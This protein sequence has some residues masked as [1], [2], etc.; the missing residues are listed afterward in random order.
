[1]RPMRVLE[2]ICPTCESSNI[3]TSRWRSKDL[4]RLL[5]LRRAVRCHD[6]SERFYVSFFTRSERTTQA[7]PSGIV[8][9]VRVRNRLVRALLSWL[10]E[11]VA[12]P[13]I[14]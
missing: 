9:H 13:R 2:L 6:C 7:V 14:E 1:M 3:R 12:A 11:P 10:G 8:L 4:L 5:A